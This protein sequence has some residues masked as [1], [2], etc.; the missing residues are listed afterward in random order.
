LLAPDIRITYFPRDS[1]R[2]LWRQYFRYG[3]WKV[4]TIRKHPRSARWRHLVAPAF[5]A[6]LLGCLLLGVI[7]RL[8]WF[9]LGTAVVFYLLL[10]L[11]FSLLRVRKEPSGLRYLPVMPV[12]FATLQVAWGLGFWWAWVSLFLGRDPLR[13]A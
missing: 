1:L 4:H 5:V 2:A 10:S 3:Y 9:L 6:E 11:A 12:V 7:W 8:F 13:P